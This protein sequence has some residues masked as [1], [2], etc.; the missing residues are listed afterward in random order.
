MAFCCSIGIN[1]Q[2]T[3]SP[4][5]GLNVSSL[6]ISDDF[7]QVD[8][9]L[10]FMLGAELK[11]SLSKRFSMGLQIQY[12]GKGF[13]NSD[14]DT[15]TIT[16]AWLHYLEAAPFLEFKPIPSFGIMAGGSIGY[17]LHESYSIIGSRDRPILSLNNAWDICGFLGL[18]Y[19]L[20]KC[21][22]VWLSAAALYPFQKLAIPMRTVRH[23]ARQ[24]STTAF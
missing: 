4:N 17:N 2:L 8:P 21:S 24:S 7:G 1:A 19:Y 14:R 10:R 20:R 5:Y 13:S 11:K 6:H 15:G 23:L 9:A 12:N 18:R 3:L 22:S 16:M